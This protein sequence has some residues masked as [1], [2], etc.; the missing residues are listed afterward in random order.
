MERGS[1][2]GDAY[3]DDIADAMA[4][5]DLADEDDADGWSFERLDAAE[6]EMAAEEAAEQA[7]QER[8]A[9]RAQA[10]EEWV[11]RVVAEQEA[12]AAA[13]GKSGKAPPRSAE[14]ALGSKW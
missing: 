11:D 8:C 3:A 1:A 9:Q 13:K 14:A 2:G 6:A 7:Y 4:E 10:E 5:T 12:T